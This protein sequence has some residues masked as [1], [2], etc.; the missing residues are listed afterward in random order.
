MRVY[1]QKA[2]FYFNEYKQHSNTESF[3]T[4]DYDL[5]AFASFEP[6]IGFKYHP[7]KG[8]S[9]KMF[10]NQ[11]LLRY[12]MMYLTRGLQSHVMTLALQTDWKVQKNK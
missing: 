9:K 6:G 4:S 12:Q 3:Y 5:S 2:S 1:V 7:Y 10:F 8:M 11:L